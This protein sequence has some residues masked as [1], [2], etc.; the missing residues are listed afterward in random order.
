MQGDSCLVQAPMGLAFFRLWYCTDTVRRAAQGGLDAI[1]SVDKLGTETASVS[2]LV[3]ALARS[4]CPF[5]VLRYCD[6]RH[7]LASRSM[8]IVCS[9]ALLCSSVH[10]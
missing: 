4:R 8:P 7:C 9:S 5:A 3:Q 10:P 6:L 2:E 1:E